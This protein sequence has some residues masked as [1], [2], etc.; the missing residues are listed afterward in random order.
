[1]GVTYDENWKA[2]YLLI[3]HLIIAFCRERGKERGR[4][5]EGMGEK[6]FLEAGIN[7]DKW[8]Y[9]VGIFHYIFIFL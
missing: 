7:G 8:L 2:H 4:E 5:R 3:T 6:W 1:M 9:K